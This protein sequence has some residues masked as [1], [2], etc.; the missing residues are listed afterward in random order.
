MSNG[1]VLEVVRFA[2]MAVEL[3][4]ARRFAALNLSNARTWSSSP[5]CFHSSSFLFFMASF[6][7]SGPLAGV[8]LRRL[9]KV[10]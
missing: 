8:A 3:G 5:S 4:L 10:E 6:A 7:V 9:L 2:V 1:L